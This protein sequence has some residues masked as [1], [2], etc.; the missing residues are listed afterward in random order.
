MPHAN[1][2]DTNVNQLNYVLSPALMILVPQCNLCNAEVW[3]LQSKHIKTALAQ[4]V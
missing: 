1:G 4:L 3:L 2:N